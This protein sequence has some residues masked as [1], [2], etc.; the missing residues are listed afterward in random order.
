MQG[1]VGN[2]LADRLR[3]LEGGV[4]LH[5]RRRPEKPAVDS[6]I[7]RSPD[8]LVFD[9]DEALHILPVVLDE[10]LPQVEDVQRLTPRLSVASSAILQLRSDRWNSHPVGSRWFDALQRSRADVLCC[11]RIDAQYHSAM[12]LGSAVAR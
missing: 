3:G 9:P 11:S 8:A 6:L 10:L 7:Y 5:Q 1:A 12:G 2:Q 4:E